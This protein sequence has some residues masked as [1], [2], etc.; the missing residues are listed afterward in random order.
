MT[1]AERDSRL[2]L[3]GV[4]LTFAALLT[5]AMIGMLM[6]RAQGG[7]PISGWLVTIL[8][9]SLVGTVAGALRWVVPEQRRSLHQHLSAL[10]ALFFLVGGG[11]L[12]V[13]GIR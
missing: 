1:P 3:Q 8:A 11:A 9:V 4:L 2:V 10:A 5:L 6:H 13:W 7:P 12:L